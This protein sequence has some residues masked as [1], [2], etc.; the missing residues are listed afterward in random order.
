MGDNLFLT[1]NYLIA[2]VCFCYAGKSCVSLNASAQTSLNNR[3]EKIFHLGVNDVWCS[4][5]IHFF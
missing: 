4:E 2:L 3:E 5:I 1:R